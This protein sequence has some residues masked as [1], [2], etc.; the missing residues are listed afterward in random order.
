MSDICL[1]FIPRRRTRRKPI[2]RYPVDACAKNKID[3]IKRRAA[4]STRS[5]S[6]DDHSSSDNSE[7]SNNTNSSCGSSDEE[8]LIVKVDDAGWRRRR[9]ES[10]HMSGCTCAKCSRSYNHV[11]IDADLQGKFAKEPRNGFTHTA[12]VRDRYSDLR[13]CNDED[14]EN[15]SKGY[16]IELVK[17]LRN[18]LSKKAETP[19]VNNVSGDTEARCAD[20]RSQICCSCR[21]QVEYNVEKNMPQLSPDP[22]PEPQTKETQTLFA[23]MKQLE[24]ESVG[25]SIPDAWRFFDDLLISDVEVQRTRQIATKFENELSCLKQKVSTVLTRPSSNSNKPQTTSSPLPSQQSPSLP[26]PTSVPNHIRQ[27]GCDHPPPDSNRHDANRHDA[28]SDLTNPQR[29]HN[30]VVTVENRGDS[31]LT[32]S[33][34]S[35]SSRTTLPSTSPSSSTFSTSP[36][37]FSSVL[38][39]GNGTVTTPASNLYCINDDSA[40]NI[41]NCDVV[42]ALG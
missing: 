11:S 24:T 40:I 5:S 37:S 28:N 14:L 15:K 42:S 18:Q 19:S 13:D 10:C 27:V 20:T 21:Q 4:P 6:L 9:R 32:P 17:D 23:Q 39:T 41:R 1:R 33:T 7:R 34:T 38:P 36:S 22:L 3:F 8:R 2:I 16:L 12:D 31:F 26:F 30:M 35:F 29:K 25:F